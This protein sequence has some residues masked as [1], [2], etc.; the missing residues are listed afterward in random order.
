MY[1]FERF[2]WRAT[3][4]QP[5]EMDTP[6]PSNQFYKFQPLSAIPTTDIKNVLANPH[7]YMPPNTKANLDGYLLYSR[8]SQYVIGTTP[9]AC[10]LSEDMAQQLLANSSLTNK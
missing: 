9:L 4:I 7:A 5:D 2:Y 8:Q 1:W 3:K 10:W 6:T